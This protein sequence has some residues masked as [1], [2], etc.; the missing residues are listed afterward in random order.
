[1]FLLDGD[2]F[3]AACSRVGD[4]V[5]LSLNRQLP[6]PRR[7][8]AAA[9][10]L[11]HLVLRHAPVL[12]GRPRMAWQ[13]READE[14]ASELLMPAWALRDPEVRDL[15]P[16]ERELVLARRFRVSRSALRA[17]L[18]RLGLVPAPPPPQAPPRS[19]GALFP[20]GGG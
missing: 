15:P 11:G 20:W 3:D 12:P 1:M 10:E 19:L 9:H 13:E 2:T 7:R 14:F 16:E 4:R 17:R 18:R 5:V 6:P 8:F